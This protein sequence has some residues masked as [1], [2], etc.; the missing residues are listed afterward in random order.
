M[1]LSNG[2]ISNDLDRPIT[3][4]HG[5]GIFEVEYLKNKSY[6]QSFHRTLIGNHTQSIERYHFE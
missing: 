4:F 3:R 1:R 5:H 6:G 2:D